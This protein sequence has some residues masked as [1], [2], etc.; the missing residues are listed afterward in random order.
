MRRRRKRRRRSWAEVSEREEWR[1]G[2]LNAR[3]ALIED[4]HAAPSC[5]TECE[6]IRRRWS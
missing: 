6:E 4:S 2:R 5:V 1:R 3:T